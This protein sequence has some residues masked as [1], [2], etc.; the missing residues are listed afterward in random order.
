MAVRG[1]L[2]AGG[3][4]GCCARWSRPGARQ[5]S[6]AGSIWTVVCIGWSDSAQS[7]ALGPGGAPTLNRIAL[8]QPAPHAGST[9]TA[10]ARCLWPS[11]RVSGAETPPVLALTLQANSRWRCSRREEDTALPCAP[12]AILMLWLVSFRDRLPAG[13]VRAQA[14]AG[15]AG[16]V[17]RNLG[18]GRG[19]GRGLGGGGGGR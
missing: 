16:R 3:L 18:R 14:Q 1:C 9:W 13:H 12:A 15:C 10:T 19:R 17:R 4:G 5:R 11:T 7:T 2:K 8:I 6:L